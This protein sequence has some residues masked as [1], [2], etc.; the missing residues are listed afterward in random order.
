MSI[1]GESGILGE[2]GLSPPRVRAGSLHPVGHLHVQ[3]ACCMLL[4]VHVAGCALLQVTMKI[5]ADVQS[6]KLSITVGRNVIT[7]NSVTERGTGSTIIVDPSVNPPNNTVYIGLGAGLGVGLLLILA[8]A[9]I[10][11][12][13]V[14]VYRR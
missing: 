6:R 10:L 9:V 14:Y 12:A 13:I 5:N 1:Q 2:E 7:V 11:G 4:A 8:I 3:V